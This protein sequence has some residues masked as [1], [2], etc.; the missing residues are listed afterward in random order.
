M[1]RCTG[2]RDEERQAKKSTERSKSETGFIQIPFQYK[3]D[4]GMDQQTGLMPP[5]L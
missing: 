5:S 2:S 4:I 1:T 3:D